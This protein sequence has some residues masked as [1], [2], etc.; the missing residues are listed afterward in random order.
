MLCT[1]Q[2][3]GGPMVLQSLKS[4]GVLP[5]PMQR[6]VAR[7]KSSELLP[8]REATSEKAL[9][10]NSTGCT[11]YSDVGNVEHE[12][13]TSTGQASQHYLEQDRQ[14]KL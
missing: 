10:I 2:N 12:E 9:G 5:E 3:V 8:E 6:S 1:T 7:A 4:N 13:Q 11:R 14:I